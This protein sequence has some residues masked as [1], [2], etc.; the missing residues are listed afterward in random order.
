MSGIK[1]WK[2]D[3]NIRTVTQKRFSQKTD[4]SG[5][6]QNSFAKIFTGFSKFYATQRHYEILS[7]SLVPTEK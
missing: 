2:G 7:K 6:W 4:F 5:T 1:F 3:E